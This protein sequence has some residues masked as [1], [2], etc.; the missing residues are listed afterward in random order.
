MAENVKDWQPIENSELP[1]SEFQA[2]VSE[3]L[4]FETYDVDKVIKNGMKLLASSGK[5]F[6]ME[7]TGTSRERMQ[8]QKK[9]LK[10]RLGIG[11]G[12]LGEIDTTLDLITEEDLII[13]TPQNTVKQE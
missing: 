8:Q 6:D 2:L 10:K 11:E 3:R 4:S 7:I 5:E 1:E 13:Q 9:N 12:V